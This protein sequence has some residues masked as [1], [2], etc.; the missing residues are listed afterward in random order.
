MGLNIIVRLVCVIN[1][2]LNKKPPPFIVNATPPTNIMM[3]VKDYLLDSFAC[4]IKNLIVLFESQSKL[5]THF[6]TS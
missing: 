3:G 5:L 1:T 2:K 6:S 4:F